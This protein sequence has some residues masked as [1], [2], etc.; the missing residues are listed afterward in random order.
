MCYL[1][2]SRL[3]L[4]SCESTRCCITSRAIYEVSF[5]YDFAIL[6]RTKRRNV[7]FVRFCPDFSVPLVRRYLV[8]IDRRREV[9]LMLKIAPDC[10]SRARLTYRN[11]PG[12]DKADSGRRPKPDAVT[13]CQPGLCICSDP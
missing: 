6:E 13:A 5:R 10:S 9:Q 7:A 2:Y 1:I 4:H 8:A 11:L 3:L 12:C